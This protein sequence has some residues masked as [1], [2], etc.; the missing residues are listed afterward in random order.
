MLIWPRLSAVLLDKIIF[1]YFD[2]FS[3]QCRRY[4]KPSVLTVCSESSKDPGRK[5]IKK[6][7][8]RGPLKSAAHLHNVCKMNGE[9]GIALQ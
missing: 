4:S 6:G 3:E 5:T 2:L 9:C 8:N 7:E 1:S